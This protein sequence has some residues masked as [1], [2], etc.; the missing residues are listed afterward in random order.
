MK[1]RRLQLF[2]MVIALAA[3]ASP[4]RAQMEVSPAPS[5]GSSNQVI[6]VPIQLNNPSA[7]PVDAFGF[8][9]SY[10]ANLLTFQS[11]STAGTL[12]AGWFAV[13]GQEAAPGTVNV[14]GFHT[15]AT[16]GSGVLLEAVFIVRTN[17]LGS[18]N[19][20]LASFVDDL[21]GANTSG[22]TFVA[23]VAPG[24]AG[25]LGEY[26]DNI[27]FTGTLLTRIDPVVNF[28]WANG[29]PDPSMGI[30]NFSVRW[31][32]WLQPDFTETYTFY[33]QTDDGVRLWVNN[34]QV[35]NSWVDQ[36]V[37]ER[38]GTIALTA[39]SL[40]PVR[41][42]FYERGGQA[43]ARLL[44]SSA[45]VEKQTIPAGRMLAAACAQG[46]GDVNG[47]GQLGADDV[48]CAFDVFLA[49][50]S[51]S[52]G[53]NYQNYA[54]ELVSADVNC[55]GQVTPADA[56]AIEQRRATTLLPAACFAQASPPPAGA[57]YQIGLLQ[58]VVDDG[59]T[60]RLCIS[61]SV[62]DAAGLDAFGARLLFP[63]AE[64]SFQRAEAAFATGGW[65]A[66]DAAGAGPGAVLLGGFNAFTEA[67]AG[68]AEL[69]RLYF[70]FLGTPG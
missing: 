25:L 18:G 26:Y 11:V 69:V 50:Q 2:A 54:C 37:T 63:G 62:Q 27:D 17:V 68:P 28:D 53:C 12:T 55:D 52:G 65:F 35:I 19:V 48:A 47:N 45:T 23:S 36:S 21:A 39:G 31:T 70:D 7:A 41:M 6:S 44:W 61:V 43:V 10:P 29:S 4:L 30:D 40:V 64:L 34:Q 15:T 60:Q 57:P 42:E 49:G 51:L 38:S 24:A 8:V 14:G 32:G 3:L 20:S 58:T 46:V 1:N 9:L 33:T 67:P 16:T 59:G 13:T 5:G 56:Q 22:A 66:V